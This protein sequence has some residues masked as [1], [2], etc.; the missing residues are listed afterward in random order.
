MGSVSIDLSLAN[1]WKNWYRFKQGKR[2]TKELE[3]FQYFLEENSRQLH[4]D[5]NNGIYQHGG[6]CKFIIHDNKR[7]EILVASIRDRI[8][9]RLLYEYLTEIYDKI[10]IYD[11]WSC[12][13]N[14][15]LVGAIERAQEFLKKYSKCYVWRSDIKKFFDNID[16]EILIKTIFLKVSDQKATELLTKIISSYSVAC[17][18]E[19]EREFAAKRNTDWQFNQPDLCQYLFK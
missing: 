10:F 6:Y 18:F 16:H 11:V 4:F 19:R 2:K 15:G 5:L 7:R 12:R 1:I 14:K 13:K 17:Q 8:V 9:H 3:H